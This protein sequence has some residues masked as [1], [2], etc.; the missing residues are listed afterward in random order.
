MVLSELRP[1]DR[2][3]VKDASALAPTTLRLMEMG[4]VPGAVVELIRRAPFGDPLE[5]RVCGTRLCLRRA[6][7]AR[8]AVELAP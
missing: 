2:A 4:V 7:A 1:G 5:I 3:T 6:D 8:I